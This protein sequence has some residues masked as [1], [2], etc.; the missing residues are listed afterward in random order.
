[1]AAALIAG[2][3]AFTASNSQPSTQTVGYGSTSV[4]GATVTSIVYTLNADGNN[5]NTVALVLTGD[6]TGS[7]VSIGFND[8]AMTLGNCGTG[9]FAAGSTT[10][11]TCDAGDGDGTDP[12]TQTT[13]SLDSTQILVN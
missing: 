4:T 3:S 11:S 12:F 7:T 6:T 13:S 10:Y 1:M 5:V 9:T 2:G 8:G